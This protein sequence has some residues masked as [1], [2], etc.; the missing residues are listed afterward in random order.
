MGTPY[1]SK[2]LRDLA[3]EL[4]SDRLRA[5]A[6][7]LRAIESIAGGET[8][9]RRRPSKKASRSRVTDEERGLALGQLNSNQRAQKGKSVGE[10]AR[11]LGWTTPR[12]RLVLRRLR[13]EGKARMTG[14]K[15]F[16]VWW[17]SAR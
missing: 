10:V 13:S 17:R 8:P 11:A 14:Q 4:G 15:R 16:A 7:L 3:N 9:S 6:E 12:A 2:E 1:S 5:T